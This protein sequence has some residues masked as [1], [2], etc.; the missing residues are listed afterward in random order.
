MSPDQLLGGDSSPG[1]GDAG[2]ALPHI[3]S[4]HGDGGRIVLNKPSGDNL[5]MMDSWAAMMEVIKIH[6]SS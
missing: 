2:L 4:L 6:H 3:P 5:E 1:S